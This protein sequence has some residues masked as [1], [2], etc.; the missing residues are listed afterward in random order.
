T[1]GS[2]SSS[3]GIHFV[4]NANQKFEIQSVGNSGSTKFKIEGQGGIVD[5]TLGGVPATGID[6][7]KPLDRFEIKGKDEGEVS[8]VASIFTADGLAF[9]STGNEGK[10]KFKFEQGTT[11][12]EG[13]TG[14]ITFQAYAGVTNINNVNIQSNSQGGYNYTNTNSGNTN[15]SGG[16]SGSNNTNSIC[17]MCQSP[18]LNIN[19]IVFSTSTISLTNNQL[20]FITIGSPTVV[21]GGSGGASGGT[22]GGSGSNSSSN[23][24]GGSSHTDVFTMT[25][26][27]STA[28]Y[29]YEVSESIRFSDSSKTKMKVRYRERGSN[30]YYLVTTASGGTSTT[31]SGSTTG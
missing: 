3:S 4:G 17:N 7:S 16:G 29:Q 2:S 23:S 5:A 1:G 24:S 14:D 8:G 10:T 6:D 18:S 25:G 19:N 13:E 15:T 11:K 12:L 21:V 20:T 22:S 27:S 30:R 28:R 9:S 26:G 31:G